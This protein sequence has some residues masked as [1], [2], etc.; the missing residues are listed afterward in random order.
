M[1]GGSYRKSDGKR[2]SIQGDGDGDYAQT[3]E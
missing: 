3:D 2:S 1:E